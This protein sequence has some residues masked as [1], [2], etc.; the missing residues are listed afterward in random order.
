MSKTIDLLGS[1]FGRLTVISRDGSGCD[2]YAS[3]LC[4]CECGKTVSVRGTN[5]R[6]G[7][8]QSCGCYN[9]EVATKGSSEKNRTHG[10]YSTRLYKV[11]CGMRRRYQDINRAN[12]K[13]YGGRGIY[14]CSD[15]EQFENFFEWS[16]NNGHSDELSIDRIDN[17]LGYEPNNCRWVTMAEQQQNKR[18]GVH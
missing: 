13:Y 8:T 18:G 16:V 11:W 4:Q 2:G 7:L 17:E 5:L 6:F 15:W 12:Y 10:Q 1:R 3:W 14:V 9:R